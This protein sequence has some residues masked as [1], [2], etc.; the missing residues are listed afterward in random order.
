MINLLL[1]IAFL[2]IVKSQGKLGDNKPQ[3]HQRN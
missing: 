1:Y 3:S 2:V